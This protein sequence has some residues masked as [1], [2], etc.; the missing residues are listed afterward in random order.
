[1]EIPMSPL[2]ARLVR[3]SKEPL[4][5]MPLAAES[6]HE[7]KPEAFGA[8]LL[9][10]DD[11]RVSSGLWECSPGRFTW[12]FVWDEF[13]H[14]HAGHV[15]VTTQDGQRIELQAGDFATFP[16]G[17]KTEWHVLEKVRK[18]FTVR[19]PDPLEL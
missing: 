10:S 13:V 15:I 5:P 1:M 11:K 3:A 16:R 2:A 18:T 14:I 19:T 12:D 9:Q 4:P 7:G 6:I 17:L 8:V